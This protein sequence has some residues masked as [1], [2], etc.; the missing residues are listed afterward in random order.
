[1]LHIRP[2]FSMG[3]HAIL[4]DAIPPDFMLISFFF[5]EERQ[6]LLMMGI[7]CYS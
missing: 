2:P 3:I 1:M 5:F 6:E 4:F 7:S